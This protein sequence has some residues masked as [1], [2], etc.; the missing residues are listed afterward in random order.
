MSLSGWQCRRRRGFSKGRPSMWRKGERPGAGKS[1]QAE[2]VRGTAARALDAWGGWRGKPERRS[3]SCG[4]TLAGEGK[5]GAA[6]R[7]GRRRS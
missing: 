2:A 7:G 6:A 5:T 4:G 3:V 1:S